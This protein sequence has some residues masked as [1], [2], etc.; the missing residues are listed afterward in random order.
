MTQRKGLIMKGIGGFYYV[1]D[2]KKVYECRGKGNLKKS[3]NKLLVGDHV[4]FDVI[5]EEEG[6]GNITEILERGNSLIRPEIANV[7]QIFLLFSAASPRPNY[8]M[9]NRYLVMVYD[10]GI[11]VHLVVNKSELVSEEER[12]EISAA[13]FNTIYPVHFISVKED[14]G[15]K[16]L[17]DLMKNKVTAL[18]GPSGV[19]KSSLMNA[20]LS[21]EIAETGELS[22]K[23][24][25]G[26][27]TTRHSEIFETGDS[28][29]VFDTPGFTSVEPYFIKEEELPCYFDEFLPLISSCKFLASCRH[30]QEKTCDCAVKRAVEEGKISGVR[31]DSYVAIRNY[32]SDIRRYS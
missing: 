21:E 17:K 4:L 32:L 24:S 19:G 15:L 13:F 18:S 7:D 22:K 10:T 27:N 12:S 23:I 28:T 11:P 29:Y 3:H 6:T 1:N 25:R 5:S 8:D 16:E 20:L 14:I 9:L 26:K 30:M 31:Y 2:G